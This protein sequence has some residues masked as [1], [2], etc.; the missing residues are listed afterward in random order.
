M[1]I[2]AA[3]R[4]R[5]VA[6]GFQPTSDSRYAPV[7]SILFL[8][9]SLLPGDLFL[10]QRTLKQAFKNTNGFVKLLIL[11]VARGPCGKPSNYVMVDDY[12]RTQQIGGGLFPLNTS[13]CLRHALLVPMPKFPL[14]PIKVLKVA[15]FPVSGRTVS[16]F[17]EK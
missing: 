16:K 15:N 7:E 5:T 8:S 10:S 1:H 6:Q 12:F 4:K 9:E 13:F 11:T 2:S 3:I 14:A 17:L